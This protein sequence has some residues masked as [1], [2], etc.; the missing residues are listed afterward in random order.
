MLTFQ[1]PNV[2]FGGGHSSSNTRA[3]AL[4]RGKVYVNLSIYLGGLGIRRL[5][6]M[7]DIMMSKVT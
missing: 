6:E 5:D 7:N 3:Y 1:V 2:G 4:K